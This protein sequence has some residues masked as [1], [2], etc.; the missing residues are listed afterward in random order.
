MTKF[1]Q[2]LVSGIALGSI[3]G[4]VALGIVLVFKATRLFNFAQGF[5]MLVGAY[6]ATTA[7]G[8]LHLPFWGAAA[9]VVAAMAVLGLVLYWI[10]VKP[11]IGRPTL[12]V[13]MVTI[14]LS[15]VI[16]AVL[17][18]VYGPIDRVFPSPVSSR[19]FDV[20]GIRVALL[21]I[22]VFAVAM[23]C[24]VLFTLF[25]RFTRLGLE[26]RASAESIEAAA[27]SGVNA[28]RVFAVALAIGTALAALG[29]ILLASEQSVV[30]TSLTDIGYVAFP[31]IVIGGLESVP[32]A[33]VGGIVVGVLELMGSGYFG[34]TA[35]NVLAYGALLAMLVIRPYGLFGE[36]DIVR[37]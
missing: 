30:S 36:R 27:L 34:A 18:M 21:D 10:V 12:V 5:L 33:I 28:S 7:I 19:S 1:V 23:G 16:S 37:V 14:A 25:F 11:L 29:G 26:M 35:S 22:V 8:N 13:V 24:V 20:L 31:A 9:A 2:L 6:L 15:I 4:L 17:A 32:G 3:Y